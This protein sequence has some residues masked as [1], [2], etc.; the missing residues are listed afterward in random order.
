M[1]YRE[2][3]ALVDELVGF[4]GKE[5]TDRICRQDMCEYDTDF[6]GFLDVYKAL[7]EIIPKRMKVIDFGCYLAFQAALFKDHDEYIGV[8]VSA[9]ERFMTDNTTHHVASIKNLIR[10]YPEMIGNDYFAICS[11]VPDEEARQLVRKT[12]SNCFVY[13]PC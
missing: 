4:Y 3:E 5:R 12:Y 7:A 1:K 9:M 10:L 13:Y 8:D 2:Y 6:F 11:Y